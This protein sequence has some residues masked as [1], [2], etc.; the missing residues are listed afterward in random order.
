MQTLLAAHLVFEVLHRV[1]DVAA[2][3]V[4]ARLMKALIQQTACGAYE[5]PS[6]LIL[7]VAGLFS[8]EH[9]FG[10]RRPLAEYKVGGV[11]IEV[12]TLTGLR[13]V[14]QLAECLCVC[15]FI[16]Q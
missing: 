10:G 16:R 15:M 12:A 7:L 5:R 14:V 8:D 3:A 11:A 9:D 2:I 6:S 1:G 4:D 13:I